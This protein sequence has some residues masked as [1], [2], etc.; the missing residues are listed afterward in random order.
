MS[1]RSVCLGLMTLAVAVAAVAQAAS[2]HRIDDMT[3]E[4]WRE[5]LAVYRERMPEEHANLF[6]RM[7]REQFNSTLDRLEN[8]LPQLSAN[9]MRVEVLRLVAMV[10]DGH[11]RVR[12]Q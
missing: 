7:T 1:L 12:P 11:T 4:K 2:S 9:Q 8:R 5:D 10:H 6:H 3:A